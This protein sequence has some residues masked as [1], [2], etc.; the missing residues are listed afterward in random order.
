MTQT[1]P[2]RAIPGWTY[3]ELSELFWRHHNRC[4]V[5]S[6]ACVLLTLL[7]AG[8]YVAGSEH[9]FML[10]PA[11]ALAAVAATWHRAS[12]RILT[13]LRFPGRRVG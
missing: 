13:K 4:L 1:E 3:D 10:A 5:A 11:Q 8:L 9:W 12:A 2:S 7:G 6:G